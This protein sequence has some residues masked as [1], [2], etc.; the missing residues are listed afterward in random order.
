MKGDLEDL[1][2]FCKVL[3]GWGCASDHPDVNIVRLK[4][5]LAREK[6][7]DYGDAIEVTTIN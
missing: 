3:D 6:H 2:R 1:M 4:K 5:R 7:Y